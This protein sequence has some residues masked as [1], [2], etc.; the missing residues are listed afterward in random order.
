MNQ[1]LDPAPGRVESD[2]WL[3]TYADDAQSARRRRMMPRKLRVLGFGTVVNEKASVLDLCCGVG[4]TLDV[5]HELGFRDLTGVDIHVPPSLEADHRFKVVE[6][7]A[8][9][10]T[11]VP[12]SSKDWILVLHA[13]HHL[14]TPERIKELMDSASRILTPNGRLSFIDFPNSLQIRAAFWFFL[15]C[16]PLLVTPY[17][18]W[19]GTI[20][21]EEWPFLQDYLPR[22]SRVWKVIHNDPRFEVEI[23]HHELFYFF[24]T[25][26]KKAA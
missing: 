6:Q 3:R 22:F 2:D 16:K 12:D 7:D 9:K 18:K 4:E 24:L 1:E 26:K 5:L 21:Q 11:F 14:E 15:N 8:C 20:T 23:E 10:P 25:V 17:L 19:F 13:L